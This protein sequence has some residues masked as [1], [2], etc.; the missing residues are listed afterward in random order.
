MNSCIEIE[1]RDPNVVTSRELNARVDAHKPAVRITITGPA[2]LESTKTSL[3]T[4]LELEEPPVAPSVAN[5]RAVEL[6]IGALK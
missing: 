2:R 6:A 3:R 1:G 4:V 5:P